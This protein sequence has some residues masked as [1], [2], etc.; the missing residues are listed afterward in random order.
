MNKKIILFTV[1]LALSGACLFASF[2]G[3]STIGVNYSY[4]GGNYFGLSTDHTGFINNGPVGYF[5][6]VDADFGFAG[7]PGYRINMLI[8][9]TYKYRFKDIPMSIEVA[10]GASLGGSSTSNVFSFGLGGYIG[11]AY[12]IN[13]SI[14]LLLGAKLGS[15]FVEV[16]LSEPSAIHVAG[17]FYVTPQLAIGFTY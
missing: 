14:E 8:G 11:A 4:E 16:P 2:N 10:A 15:N 1:V 17:D 6:G 9:P 5:V 12:A 13:N 3:R 7:T